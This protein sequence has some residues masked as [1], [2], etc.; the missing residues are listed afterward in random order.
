MGKTT[1]MLQSAVAAALAGIPVAFYIIGDSTASVIY[2]KAA[3]ILAE[4]TPGI[5]RGFGGDGEFDRWA[6]AIERLSD[7]PLYVYDPSDVEPEVGAIVRSIRG[8]VQR[9]GVQIVFVDSEQQ[10]GCAAVGKNGNREQVVA[11]VSRGLLMACKKMNLAVV[12]GSQ[13]SRACETR[14]GSKRP[15]ASDMRESGALEQDADNILFVY[16]AEVYGMYEDEDGRDLRGVTELI[17]A[18]DRLEGPGWTVYLRQVSHVLRDWDRDGMEDVAST[19]V[20]PVV[21]EE[22]PDSRTES[23]RI[24][25]VADPD[26]DDIPF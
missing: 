20:L 25:K 10:I 14:G 7:L 1:V 24:S 26:D 11:G 16:R 8:E 22:H 12:A 21:V 23:V 6:E 13:L 19:G 18:K 4:V 2:S 17:C 3:A 9:H 5:V 15:I